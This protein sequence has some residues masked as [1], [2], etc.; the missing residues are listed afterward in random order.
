M[1]ML[2]SKIWNVLHSMVLIEVA[3]IVASTEKV[4]FFTKIFRFFTT[5]GI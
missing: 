4:V 3:T 2:I 1:L 5:K